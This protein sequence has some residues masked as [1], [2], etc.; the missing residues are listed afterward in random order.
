ME[1]LSD[2]EAIEKES[3]RII[4]AR[5]AGKNLPPVE[6]TIVERVIH[7]TADFA[8]AEDLCFAP[9]AVQSGLAALRQGC[10]VV[11]DT[12]MAKAGIN[13]KL[14]EAIGAKVLCA[15]EEEGT[16]RL[17]QGRGMTR[18]MAAMRCVA[19]KVHGAIFLI[20]NA[21][22]ALF[23]LVELFQEGKLSSPLVVGVPV[24]LVGAEEAKKALRATSLPS[25][26]T[27]GPKGG[28]PVAVAIF[29]ALCHL[30]LEGRHEKR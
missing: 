17:A 21:P 5:I 18:A 25:I 20:G 29:H 3:F 26:T 15:F 28:T 24:G 14:L 30:T 10:L 9:G 23:A 8:Y 2:P 12:R 16:E 11:T 27:L 19:S 6:R 7:A 4:R 13:Q 1:Y 22:T